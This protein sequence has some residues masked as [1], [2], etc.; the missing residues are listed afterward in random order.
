[1][2][3]EAIR[4]V[5]LD[6]L[7]TLVDLE[8]P[9]PRL[10]AGLAGHGVEVTEEEAARA[11]RAE[12]A[13]Y[14]ANLMRGRDLAALAELR[15]EC[16]AVTAAA[17]PEAARDL[18]PEV[19]ERVLLDALEFTPFGEVVD[20]LTALRERGLTLIVVSNWDVSLHAMLDDTGLRPLVDGA[21]ASAEL[22]AAKPAPAPF[23][24]ALAL[25]GV[26]PEQAWHVGDDLDADI[27]G[28]AALGIRPVLVDRDGAQTAPDGVLV[29]PDLSDLVLRLN[30]AA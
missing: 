29:V 15:A 18:A 21:V 10:R 11:V 4:A 9:A 27:A 22:G 14:R 30:R 7:G 17:L 25:A 16:A 3:P 20:A 12:I 6:A 8:P 28:A 2:A 13:F 19:L 26:E 1:M 23:E 5:F 24:R